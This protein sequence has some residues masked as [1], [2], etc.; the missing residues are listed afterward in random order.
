[1]NNEEYINKILEM[2]KKM[3]LLLND[4]ELKDMYIKTKVSYEIVKD[5]KG[6]DDEN[7]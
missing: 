5:F 3:I 1:M 4:E 7:N 6:E 2:A